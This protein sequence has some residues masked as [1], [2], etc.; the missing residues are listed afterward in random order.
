M[1]PL[2]RDEQVDAAV[3]G[4]HREAR[5]GPE[6]RLV[7]HADL[8]D[9]GDHHLGG[10]RHE[11]AADAHMTDQVALTEG[12]AALG[13]AG[14]R[15]RIGVGVHRGAPGASAADAS[16]TGVST[17]YST[18]TRAAARRAVS[19]WSAATIATGSPW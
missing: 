17:S 8:V 16:V 3:L 12:L 14:L 18:T 4:R 6:E 13:A 15:Q 5:L 11:P 19:G 1:Q 2:G 9:A 7:L 10:G